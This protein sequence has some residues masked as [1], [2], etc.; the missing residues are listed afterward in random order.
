MKTGLKMSEKIRQCLKKNI[1]RP[2]ETIA[3]KS[4]SKLQR[5]EEWFKTF[6]Q[7]CSI[8]IMYYV[9]TYEQVFELRQRHRLTDLSRL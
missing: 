8:Y 1:E 4:A 5:N 7:Y 6:T 2:P 9:Y 3:R